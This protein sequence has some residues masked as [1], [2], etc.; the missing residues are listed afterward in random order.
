MSALKRRAEL[1]VAPLLGVAGLQVV[2]AGRAVIDLRDVT[3]RPLAAAYRAGLRPFLI[4]VTTAHCRVL[5]GSAFACT[6]TV[7]NPFVDTLLAYEANRQLTYDASPLADF[8]RR[9][10]PPSLIAVLGLD[11]ENVSPPLAN[12]PPLGLVLPWQSLSP[13]EA[14][15]RWTHFIELDNREHGTRRDKSA[16]WKGWGPLDPII[17][18]Q[19]F[20]RLTRV[21]EAI[22]RDGYRRSDTADGDIKG[23]VL[24]EMDQFRVMVTAGHHRASALAALGRERAPV[25]IDNPLVRREDVKDWPNVRSGL[26]TPAQA[27]KIFDRIFEGAQPP[28]FAQQR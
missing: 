12:A 20:R 22:E 8:Y 2:K 28:G 10:Q 26:F 27:L 7:G 15:Q 21:F 17:G 25:R 9:W 6:P 11:G 24:Q 5:P 18:E 19:E 3:D 13:T 23:V 4:E 16:G 14:E 1:A